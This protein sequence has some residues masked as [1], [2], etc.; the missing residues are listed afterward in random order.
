MPVSPL[1]KMIAGRMVQSKLAIPHATTQM[2]VDMSNVV[3]FRNAHK[4]DFQNREGVSLSYVAFVIKVTVEALKEYPMVNAEWAGDNIIMKHDV[5]INVAVDAPE[6]LTT[7]VIHHA[8][9]RS[10]AGLS[11]AIVDLSTR[12]RNKKLTVADM[13]GGTFTVNNTGSLGSVGS[14]SIINYPQAGIL[15]ANAI[16]KRPVVLEQDGEDVI[17]VRSMMNLSFSFDHRLL[18]GGTAT[19]FVNAVKGKLQSWSLDYPIY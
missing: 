17:A 13:Q 12:A 1:R 10:L 8:D 9:D 2:E 16:V 14:V 7:P 6:G 4:D 3:R 18:D 5:N 15:T 11:K 19:G